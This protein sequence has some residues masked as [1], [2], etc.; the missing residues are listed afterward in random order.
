LLTIEHMTMFV[1]KSF[2]IQIN[3]HIM[4]LSI[5]YGSDIIN[6]KLCDHDLN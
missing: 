2:H 5:Y 6:G 1:V 3:V 4:D